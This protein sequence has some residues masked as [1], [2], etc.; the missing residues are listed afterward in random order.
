MTVSKESNR[1]CGLRA[2]RISPDPEIRIVFRIVVCAPAN[3]RLE[4]RAF[5][6]GGSTEKVEFAG[7]KNGDSGMESRSRAIIVPPVRSLMRDSGFHLGMKSES[8]S[9]A[10]VPAIMIHH[11]IRN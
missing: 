4:L 3:K 7:I 2:H 6:D 9:T 8:A 5:A 10:R 1:I 11:T